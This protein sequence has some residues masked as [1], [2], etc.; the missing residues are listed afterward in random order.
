MGSYILYKNEAVGAKEN[1]EDVAT[2]DAQTGTVPVGILYDR[3]VTDYITFEN[4]GFDLHDDSRKFYESGE[5]SGFVSNT[6]SDENGVFSD[7]G[8]HFSLTI[9]NGVTCTSDGITITFW[10]NYCTSVRIVY[11]KGLTVLNDTTY[12]CAALSCFFEKR[13]EGYNEVDFYFLS[14]EAP[15]QFAKIARIDF[16][17]DVLLNTLYSVNLLEELHLT[18]DD[19]SINTLD[20]SC[21]SADPLHIQEDQ[22]FFIYHKAPGEDDYKRIGKFHAD[23]VSEDTDAQY[24]ISAGDDVTLLEDT[25]FRGGLWLSTSNT[26]EG[27]ITLGELAAKIEKTSHV[28]ILCDAALKGRHLIGWI[29]Y[30][31]CREALTLA[32]FAAGAV[33]RAERS[34]ALRLALPNTRPASVPKIPEGRILGSAKF[35]KNEGCTG[36]ELTRYIY[37]GSGEIVSILKTG[38]GEGFST[39]KLVKHSSPTAFYA[40][41][42]SG[43]AVIGEHSPSYIVIE[44][45]E[46]DAEVKGYRYGER[47]EVL[48]KCGYGAKEKIK[49]FGDYTLYCPEI[50]KL[51]QL[52]SR[53]V[54]TEGRVTAKIVLNGEQVGDWVTVPTKYSGEKTG[55]ITSL[56]SRVGN[57]LVAEAVIECL[58]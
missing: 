30:G 36:V 27:V 20:F 5:A 58:L 48:S 14:T 15:H 21:R 57:Y 56:D 26:L 25:I 4:E 29:P 17:R 1:I 44:S 37:T 34:G 31:S 42:P 22:L 33:V 24:T 6:V 52:Y 40:V 50:D 9:R 8:V 13:V 43:H 18:G 47:Q 35:E 32:A 55:V 39:P 19:L 2:L 38:T 53:Y 28:Q 12:P 3:N 41:S 46:A 11:K 7:G 10:Q 45:M 49:S 51:S 23:S 54:E 16:G